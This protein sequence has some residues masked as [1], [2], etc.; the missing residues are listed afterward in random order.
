[1]P[2]RPVKQVA[3]GNAKALNGS[4]LSR[5]LDVKKLTD[6][7]VKMIVYG[8][9]R[10]GKTKLIS[11]FPKPIA[12]LSFEPSYTGGANTISKVDGITIYQFKYKKEKDD[13][14]HV[15]EGSESAYKLA[16]ELARDKYFKTVGFDSA[17]SF[18]DLKLQEILGLDTLPAQMIFGGITGDDYRTRSERTKEG[19]RP[20]LSL[21]KHVII[22]AKEKDHNPPK[23]EKVNPKTGKKQPDMRPKFLRGVG[24][25]SV[26]GA[27]LGGA[28][29]GW[30]YDACENICQLQFAE[31]IETKEVETNVLGKMRTR[32]E[33][34][35]TGKIGRRLRL[36]YHPNYQCGARSCDE[37]LP[38]FIDDP[39]FDNIYKALMGGE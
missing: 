23:D 30:L 11:T 13:G 7:L 1:M 21:R 6:N 36:K 16:E 12:L 35:K 19:L 3:T 15:F 27:D 32:V 28:T 22:T 17:T 39:D 18:Q 34:I 20:F 33:E 8:V 37:N 4:L 25:E 14:E 10:V 5:G 26:F 38:E 9:N 24:E 31:E 2:P 29:A